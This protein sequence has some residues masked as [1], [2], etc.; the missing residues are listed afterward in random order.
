MRSFLGRSGFA[1]KVA[2]DQ[3][4]RGSSG[5]GRHDFSDNLPRRD[6]FW[7]KPVGAMGQEREAG[8]VGSG[9]DPASGIGTIVG[10]R[11]PWRVLGSRLVYENPWIRVREDQ[12]LRP[13]GSP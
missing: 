8:N 7:A 6:T 13:D 10:Q 9:G 12:V 1:Q 4:S 2:R 11:G 3:Q 5:S